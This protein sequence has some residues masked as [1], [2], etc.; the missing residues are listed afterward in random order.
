MIRSYVVVTPVRD[1][2]ENLPRLAASL[3]EQ[4]V[5]PQAWLIVDNG[6]T[7]GTLELAKRLG[8]RH[9]W[10]RVLTIPGTEA[11][12]R[13]GPVVRALHAAIASITEHPQIFV[14]V[15]ADISFEPDYFQRLLAHFD[16]DPSLGIAS[17]SA[18]ELNG[19]DWE[20]RFVTGS[21]VWGA[22]RAYR[23]DCLQQL[24][25][26][27][28]R[29]AWDGVDEFKANA[30]GWRTA[31]FEDLP[32]RHHRREGERDGSSWRVAVNQGRTAH[33]LAYRPSYLVMRALWHARRDPAAVA[34]LW[35]YAGSAIKREPQ[36]ADAEGRAYLRSQQSF[37]NV[38]RRALEASGRRATI[39]ARIAEIADACAEILLVCSSGGHLQQM[40]ALQPTWE[41]YS[42]VWVTFD[43]SDVQSLLSNERVV[44]AHS[45]T[46]RSLKNLARNLVLAWRTLRTVRP[47]VVLSTGAGVA[48]PFAWLGRLFGAR[49]VYVESFTRVEGLSLS[50]RLVRPVAHRLYV[51]WPELAQSVSSAEYPGNVFAR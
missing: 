22:S 50:G 18:Y 36:N 7:D 44:F 16:E 35:G 8:E 26:L 37:R 2:E 19:D 46:N 24:L 29:V 20:Q 47:R 5:R 41:R 48:V 13:G 49:I 15:D 9:E 39:E 42:H 38:R 30:R 25:P 27:E 28:Q 3:A 51:Q 12:D 11:A 10:I 31:T 40:L 14:N 45:P 32:F 4:A 34:M 43:K 23:W 17:G 6:S 21:T 1:E 33:F